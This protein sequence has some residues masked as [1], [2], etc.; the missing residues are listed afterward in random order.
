MSAYQLAQLNIAHLAAP[1]DSPVLA[2]FVASLDRVNALA[3]DSPG[4]VWRLQTEDG[5][6]TAIRPFGDDML[7]NMSVWENV[8]ALHS[9]VYK[10]AHAEVMRRRK[11]WFEKTREVYM[12]LW[13]VPT[14]HRPS[15]AEAE[16][17]LMALREHGPSPDAFTF[18]K[19]HRPPDEAFEGDLT[20]FDDTCPA[21]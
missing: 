2:D 1:I 6:A 15:L 5:N 3:D 9:Y 13:W 12:V 21:T 18:R 14:G 7:V 4:F 11:E 10:S 20:P 17:K 16:A 8:E 19:P